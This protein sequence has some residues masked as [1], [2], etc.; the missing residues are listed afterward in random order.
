MFTENLTN[1]NGTEKEKMENLLLSDFILCG[2]PLN[3]E[4]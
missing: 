1:G 2:F 3:P 4:K